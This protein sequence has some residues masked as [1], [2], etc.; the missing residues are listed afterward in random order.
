MTDKAAQGTL[1]LRD[2][3]HEVSIGF[4][5]WGLGVGSNEYE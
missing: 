2:S 1:T 4:A 3:K 5:V